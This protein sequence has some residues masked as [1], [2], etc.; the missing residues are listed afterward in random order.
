MGQIDYC[1]YIDTRM[2][3]AL[4]IYW[5]GFCGLNF[6]LN[7]KKGRVVCYKKLN[8]IG[9]YIGGYNTRREVI[10]YSRMHH[11]ILSDN[12]SSMVSS[13]SRSIFLRSPLPISWP[14]WQGTDVTLPSL[15]RMR[16][17]LP[18]WR[19]ILKSFLHRYFISSSALSI[20]WFIINAH[21]LY[22]Y[23]FTLNNWVFFDAHF[24]YVPHVVH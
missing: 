6:R 3:Q 5:G 21:F 1:F 20:G 11:C 4:K 22:A 23:E 12:S 13:V 17:W 19:I 15:W 7:S 18:F 9:N 10:K 24:N 16:T 2:H 8:G 14:E